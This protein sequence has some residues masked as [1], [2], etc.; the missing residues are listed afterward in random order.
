MQSRKGII[1]TL[2][3][4]GWRK[5]EAHSVANLAADI[6]TGVAKIPEQLLATEPRMT[7]KVQRPPSAGSEASC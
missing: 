2:T 5:E 1:Q 7:F 4:S 6:S 3:S